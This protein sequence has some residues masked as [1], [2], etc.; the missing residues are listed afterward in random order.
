MS[1]S[2]RRIRFARPVPLSLVVLSVVLLGGCSNVGLPSPVTSEGRQTS[3]LWKVFMGVAVVIGV[4]VLA[5]L[6]YALTRSGRQTSARATS[7]DEQASAALPSQR[8]YQLRVE[9]LLVIIPTIIVIV[10]LTLSARTTSAITKLSANPDETIE[11]IGFQWQWQFRYPTHNIVIT[12]E[13]GTAPVLMLPTNRTVR[14]KLIANDVAHS[15]WVP[16][17][18]SKRDLI[19]GVRNEIDV[20]VE[21]NGTW[22]GVCS[23]YCGLDH[24]KM[25]FEVKAVD[26]A[27]YDAWVS[28]TTSAQAKEQ[29]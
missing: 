29:P 18:L 5:V 8:Q 3:D 26:P 12:G 11:V 17:F 15:F 9:T 24:W 19:P 13:P 10:L 2:S 23:E 6:L 7:T 14:L 20:H 25:N 4:T 28:K 22:S 1:R 21:K 16:K 27:T